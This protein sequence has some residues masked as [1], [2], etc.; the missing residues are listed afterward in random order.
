M[1]YLHSILYLTSLTPSLTPHLSLYLSLVLTMQI[2]IFT[3]ES[4]SSLP[5]MAFFSCPRR[6]LSLS[7]PAFVLSAKP[8]HP[9]CSSS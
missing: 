3:N 9:H 6:C 8:L 1:L 2:C 5:A 4:Y 7:A